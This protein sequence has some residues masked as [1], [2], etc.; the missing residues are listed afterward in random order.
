MT[1]VFG[2]IGIYHHPQVEAARAL[3]QQLRETLRPRVEAVWVSSA[4]DP[5]AST[6][7]LPGTELLICIGGDGTVLRGARAV[8]PHPTLILGVDMGRL[9][10][11]TEFTPDDLQAHLDAILAGAYD[12]EERAM[13]EV[14][15]EG[16]EDGETPET[17]LALNDVIVGRMSLGRPVYLNVRV[18]GELIGVLRG[19]G[20]VVATA[21]GSTGYSL[22][23]G[24][25][26]LDPSSRN[27]VLTP[28]A[29]HLAAAAPLV[30]PRNAVIDLSAVEAGNVAVSL[31][32]QGA[33]VMGVASRVNIRRS[34]HVA[35]MLRYWEKPF[36]AQLG[37]RL[38][39][40][41][42]RRLRAA[43]QGEE[44]VRLE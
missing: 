5:V 24:G 3:A 23:A 42:E 31:D 12:V 28:I 32:G 43:Q 10:F 16:F 19:D 8:V 39:W 29:P 33:H 9:A 14:T 11:L 34:G 4:W 26:I 21:T 15:L 6:R 17:A 30:L 35:R 37:H 36:F 41:D 25:P 22:S 44:G 38:A 20:V 1:S 13:L 2:K 27:L 40:L 18:N 7:D